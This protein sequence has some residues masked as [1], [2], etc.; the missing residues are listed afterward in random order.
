MLKKLT[1]RNFKAIQD[2]VIEFTPLTVLIGENACGKS[3]ILQALDFLRSTAFRDIP[4]YLREKGWSFEELK[5]QLNDGYSKSIEFVS[6][7]EFAGETISW[8]LQIDKEKSNWLINE[9]IENLSTNEVYF[10]GNNTN[11]EIMTAG[12]PDAYAGSPK[13]FAQAINFQASWLKYWTGVMQHQQLSMP[14][15][16]EQM[17]LVCLPISM[18]CVKTTEI[19]LIIQFQI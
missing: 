3:S 5:S 14:K 1:I 15:I 17:V 16:L 2:L 7:F 9:K 10:S 12:A 18:V 19:F 11:K 8:F 6:I 13:A 4:E